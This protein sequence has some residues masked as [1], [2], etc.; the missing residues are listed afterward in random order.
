MPR[1]KGGGFDTE[2]EIPCRLH[3]DGLV[4]QA[5]DLLAAEALTITVVRVANRRGVCRG[6]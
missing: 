5:A 6:L 1:T 2:P 3:N 4:A